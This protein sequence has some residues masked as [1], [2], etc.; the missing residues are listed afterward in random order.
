MKIEIKLTGNLYNEVV[1]DMARPH[2]VAAER[3]GFVLGRMGTLADRGIAILLNWY[4]SIPDSQYMDDPTVCARINSEALTW[5][6]QAVYQGRSAREGIFHIHMH[7]HSG[8]TGMSAVDSRE[9]PKL[10]PG[11][12]SVSN[13]AVHGIIILSQITAQAWCGCHPVKN[14][15]ALIVSALSVPRSKF[16]SGG[17]QNEHGSLFTPVVSRGKF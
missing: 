15:A 14:R 3:V 7:S 10:I 13:N 2:P 1:Q 8:E 6:M 12:Q 16:S 5:A 9:I 11:F 17:G 4:H